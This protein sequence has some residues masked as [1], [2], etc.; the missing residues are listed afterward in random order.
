MPARVAHAPAV[1]VVLAAVKV[2][3]LAVDGN[4]SSAIVVLLVR[5]DILFLVVD[6]ARRH[7]SMLFGYGR[8]LRGGIIGITAGSGTSG[9]GGGI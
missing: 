2:R 3:Q 1:E 6:L 8:R 5:A 9:V 7:S 4:S